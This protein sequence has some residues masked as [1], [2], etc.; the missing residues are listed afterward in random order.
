MK[1]CQTHFPEIEDKGVSW[2]EQSSWRQ[3]ATVAETQKKVLIAF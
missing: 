3:P 1:P 2:R